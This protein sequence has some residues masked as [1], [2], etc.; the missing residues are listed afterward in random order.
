MRIFL[1]GRHK[2]TAQL[3][4]WADGNT[5]FPRIGAPIFRERCREFRAGINANFLRT[6]TRVFRPKLKCI[7][8]QSGC[9]LPANGD[10]NLL[11]TAGGGQN[12]VG[13]QK[14]GGGGASVYLL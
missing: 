2:F 6:V 12:S 4:L 5:N 13:G 10:A 3:E 1:E 14:F 8:P 7:F 9:K 11:R